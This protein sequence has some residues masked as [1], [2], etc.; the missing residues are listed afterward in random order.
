MS[1]LR[2]DGDGLA[3]RYPAQRDADT[4]F[5]LASDARVTRY[6]SWGPYR[7]PQEPR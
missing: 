7:D 6:F 2:V 1:H 5:T 4:L 3:L